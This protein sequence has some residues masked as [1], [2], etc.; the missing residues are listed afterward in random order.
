MV[1]QDKERFILV[2]LTI[3]FLCTTCFFYGMSH[4]KQQEIEALKNE[5]RVVKGAFWDYQMQVQ[6]ERM[7]KESGTYRY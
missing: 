4:S 3:I 7:I 6:K 1:Q 5:V 2:L